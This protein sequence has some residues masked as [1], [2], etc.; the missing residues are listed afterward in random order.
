MVSRKDHWVVTGLGCWGAT[1]ALR[2]LG[3]TTYSFLSHLEGSFR[4]ECLVLFIYM[5]LAF[6]GNV[7]S[8]N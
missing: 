1:G 3:Q 4:K 6:P 8:K 2:D 5:W 7:F